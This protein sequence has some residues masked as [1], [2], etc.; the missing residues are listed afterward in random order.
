MLLKPLHSPA[1][2]SRSHARTR[3]IWTARTVISNDPE[4]LLAS[5]PARDSELVTRSTAAI[6]TVSRSVPPP[7]LSK[8][9]DYF[10]SFPSRAIGCLSLGNEDGTGPYTFSHAVHR[11]PE[12][13]LELVIPFRSDIEGVPKIALGREVG[14]KKQ[15]V[16]QSEWAGDGAVIPEDLPDELSSLEWV[17]RQ[18]SLFF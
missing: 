4:E 11:S 1:L 3:K 18:T 16:H 17:Y 6:F 13:T 10:Q 12:N 14:R 9:V 7:V 15:K 2:I 5:L 8:I